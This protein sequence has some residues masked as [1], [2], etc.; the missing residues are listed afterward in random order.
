MRPGAQVQFRVTFPDGERLAATDLGEIAISP[1]GRN[2]VYVAARG[3]TTQLSIHSL[4]WR[5]RL[6]CAAPSTP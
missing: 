5:N 2:V 1:D 3:T 4:D 6:R